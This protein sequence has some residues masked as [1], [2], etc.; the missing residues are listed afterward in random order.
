MM[1][2]EVKVQLHID[3]ES[4]LGDEVQPETMLNIEMST[5]VSSPAFIKV[6]VPMAIQSKLMHVK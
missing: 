1:D 2:E 4:A 3:L 6:S 5:G